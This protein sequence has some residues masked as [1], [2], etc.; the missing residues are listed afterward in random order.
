M[1]LT[2]LLGELPVERFLNDHYLRFPFAR[3]GGCAG[4]LARSG[5]E[6]LQ[7]ALSSQNADVLFARAAETL[8]RNHVFRAVD[9]IGQGYTVRVRHAEQH[10]ADLE[11]LAN[12]FR[13]D[14]LA[15]VDIHLYCTPANHE[16]LNWHF[17]AEDV[18]VLQLEG[19]KT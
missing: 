6:L 10:D 2:R 19:T 11:L 17:D 18:F 15:P 14:F 5:W 13:A 4:L 7:G 1:S 8:D 16:G 12:K 3:V 9:L